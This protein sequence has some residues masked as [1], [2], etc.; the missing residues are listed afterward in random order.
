MRQSES[1]TKPEWIETRSR[2][3]QSGIETDQAQGNIGLKI[4]QLERGGAHPG[5][6]QL[7]TSGDPILTVCLHI[8][9]VQ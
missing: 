7:F 4:G 1:E 2:A 6:G 8:D 3:R 5:R 9:E